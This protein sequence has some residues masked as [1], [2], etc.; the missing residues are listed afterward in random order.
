MAIGVDLFGIGSDGTCKI[1]EA[2]VKW[3][4]DCFDL[5][6]LRAWARGTVVLSYASWDGFDT[7]G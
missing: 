1:Q 3:T 4:G 7:R 2:I 6:S 5:G